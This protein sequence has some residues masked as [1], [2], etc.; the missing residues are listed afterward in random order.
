M[1]GAQGLQIPNLD[2]IRR[3]PVLA[4]HLD[5]LN[6]HNAH[7][8]F[9]HDLEMGSIKTLSAALRNYSQSLADLTIDNFHLHQ[10]FF[11]P[12]MN[13]D[14]IDM[15]MMRWTWPKLTNIILDFGTF[16][17]YVDPSQSSSE[18]VDL[19]IAAGRAAMN[20]P[21]LECFDVATTD[22]SRDDYGT[23]FRLDR[24]VLEIAEEH[25]KCCVRFSRFDDDEE[26]RILAAWTPFMRAEARFVRWE[27]DTDDDDS[28]HEETDD[29]DPVAVE[30]TRS[31]AARVFETSPTTEI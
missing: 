13:E 19:L 26:Q 30:P 3:M 22:S 16:G 24:E 1:R 11:E 9:V 2:L 28:E 20:M 15:A 12:F 17:P 10:T 8:S 6:I 23:F 25:R 14:Q 31:N 4:P 5:E 29:A 21:V 27:L 7:K 18:A